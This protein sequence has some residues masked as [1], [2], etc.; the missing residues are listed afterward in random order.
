MSSIQ[1]HIHIEV[2]GNAYQY[3]GNLPDSHAADAAHS[4]LPDDLGTI[5]KQMPVVTFNT[6]RTTKAGKKAPDGIEIRFGTAR[7]TEPVREKLKQHGF[8]FSEKQTMWYAYDT[9]KSRELAEKWMTEEV[10]VDTTQYVKQNFW[11]LIRSYH[12]YNQLRDR[13]ELWV[14]TDS[15]KNFYSKEYLERA[16]SVNDLI[17]SGQLYFK[18]YFNKAVDSDDEPG[19][20]SLLDSTAIAEKLQQLADNMKDEI[21]RKIHSAISK[22]RPTARRLRIAAGLREEGYRLREIQH[23]LFALANAHRDGSIEK[24]P[25][26]QNIR[27]RNQVYLLNKY[28]NAIQFNWKLSEVYERNEEYLHRLKIGN[29]EQWAEAEEQ[30]KLLLEAYSSTNQ[31]LLPPAN[32]AKI[33]ELEMKAFSEDIPGFFPS[34]AE[35]IKHM[36]EVAE[37]EPEHQIIDPSAG[38]GD[39]LEAISTYLAIPGSNLYAC[40]INSTLREIL[41]LKGFTLLNRDFLNLK[42]EDAKFDRILMNPPFENG[43]DA[44]HITHA[45]SLLKTGGRLVAIAGEGVFFRGFKKETAFRELLREKNAYVSDTIT[46]AFKDAFKST[47]V[48]VRL[49]VINQD[50]TSPNINTNNNR[51]EP[52]PNLPGNNR[53]PV[54]QEATALL[55]L[56]AEAE[57]ELLKL[58][59]EIA[60]KRKQR[61]LNGVQLSKLHQFRQRAW[62]LQSD[63]AVLDFK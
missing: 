30:K 40:E 3:F 61:P 15:P 49:V 41:Q 45:L 8:Q 11:A 17:S 38:K 12:E 25:F 35:L 55:E 31:V 53:L 29:I 20:P 4:F 16:Y 13:T 10:E 24:F 23:I 46:E 32:E 63:I 1:Q 26:L 52:S 21:E 7:P 42:S 54:S 48:N 58:R 50:G 60:R 39:I 9:E 59:L 5:E 14:K 33:R 44:D 56:E 19:E 18:K 22:Q 57:L 51:I 62:A 37:L 47:H 43:Q 6:N 36:I 2:H 28:A 27:S 34:P